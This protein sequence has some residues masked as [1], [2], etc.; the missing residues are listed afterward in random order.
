VAASGETTAA[1]N[2]A[3]AGAFMAALGAAGVRDACVT[4]GSRSTPLTV[5]LAEQSGIR[6]WLHLDERSAAF[7]ALGLARATGRPV[8]LVCTSGTAAAN[9]FP[10][11]VEANLSRIPLIVCTADRPPRLRDMGAD[12]TMLQAGMFGPNVRW[13][14]DLPVPSSAAYE[15]PQFGTYATRAAAAAAGPLPGPVHLNFPFE[16]PLIGAATRVHDEHRLPDS[17]EFPSPGIFAPPE[18]NV[19]AAT[20][21]LR[22]AERPL[23]VAGPEAEGLPAAALVALAEAIQAPILADGLSGLRCGP[24]DRSLVLDS[25]DAVLRADAA[26]GLVPDCVVRLGAKPTSKALNQ[27]LARQRSA[28]HI[29]CE[30]PGGWRDPDGLST[31]VLA[32]TPLATVAA[33]QRALPQ[34]A[35]VGDWAARWR[36]AD[37]AARGALQSCA[38]GFQDLFE[39]RIFS[40]LQALLPAGA[41]L[42]AGNSMPVRDLDSFLASDAKALTLTANRGA[43]GI[44]G[45]TS[46]ALGAA[47]AGQG[48]VVLVIGDISF[49]HDLNGLWAA[50]RHGLDLTV[51]L[52][53]NNGGGI[54]HYLPQAA[55]E[56]VFEDWFGTPTNLDFSLAVRMY[57]GRHTLARD[58]PTFRDAVSGFEQG[59]LRVVELPTN[60]VR[61]TDMHREAWAAAAVAVRAALATTPPAPELTH[62]T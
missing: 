18:A 11:V 20:E 40:E 41:T 27:F 9:Y 14:A 25:F 34:R 12:Q 28:A 5:A 55:H 43:A 44:D 13:A 8:A 10:A 38:A 16:E 15:A 48:P 31:V 62:A 59:G 35:R 3:A 24:H 17:R 53:N 54:F 37:A 1:A 4:P 29:L 49:Y 50:A 60:R 39:G 36:A 26:D 57:G 58:W 51:V 23:I 33:L 32:G 61:N 47:A 46:S 7:F 19:A 30:L 52:V 6:P 56:E 42:M 2:R 21:M 45:V 22:R